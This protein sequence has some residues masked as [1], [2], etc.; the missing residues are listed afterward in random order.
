MEFIL[1][2]HIQSDFLEGRFGWYR[3]LCGANYYNTVLQFLQA[4]KP[5]RIRSLVKMGFNLSDIK[6][7]FED[8]ETESHHLESNVME[9]LEN[10]E[11]FSFEKLQNEHDEAIVYTVAGYIARNLIKN[12]S[13]CQDCS[14][15]LS[16]GKVPLPLNV[17]ATENISSPEENIKE[18]FVRNI[19]R[20]GLLKPSDLLYVICTHA[21]MMYTF[22]INDEQKKEILL[23]SCNPRKVFVE[24]FIQKCESNEFANIILENMCN[25]G[26][27]IRPFTVKALTTMFNILVIRPQNS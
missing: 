6:D 15:M 1:T 19:T 4:K 22:I 14:N 5:I 2:G 7:I 10:I 25:Q 27:S 18:E 9:M 11:N 12:M 16:P 20:G 21:H 23:A 17:D 13:P 8:G 3:Q 24:T 26:H